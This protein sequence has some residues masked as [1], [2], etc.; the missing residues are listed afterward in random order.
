MVLD[1]LSSGD[2]AQL[3]E[4]YAR[5]VMLLHLHRYAQW[6]ELFDPQVVVQSVRAGAATERYTG[7]DELLALSHRMARGEFDLALGHLVPPL[8]TS[9][10]LSNITLFDERRGHALGYAFLTVTT[11]AGA[12]PPR[13]LASGL[14]T[15][16]FFKC[17]AGCWRFVRRVLQ[18]D[19]KHSCDAAST[20]ANTVAQSL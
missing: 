13:W 10:S 14:Y 2:R 7:R 19:A 6:T 1:T 16:H 8:L 5:S 3:I 12:D 20:L 11:V 17:P 18:T 15:D 4:L 9:H